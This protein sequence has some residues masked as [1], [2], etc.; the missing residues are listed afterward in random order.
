MKL[1]KFIHTNK[2]SFTEKRK[3][4]LIIAILFSLHTFS[5]EIR[6]CG[7]NNRKDF[8]L[9]K[10]PESRAKQNKLEQNI[11]KW[12]KENTNTKTS[13]ITI[14]VV[15]HVVY[16]NNL[17]NISDAQIQSQIDVLNED[18]RRLNQDASNT[19]FDFLPYAADMQIEFCLAKR[20]LGFPTNGIIR[21]QTNLA[22]F[23]LYSDSVFFTNF[24]GSSAWNTN[25]YLNIWVC[26]I[27]NNV[28]GWAQFPGGGN[29]QT[30][31][32][33]IDF[34]RIGTIG[35]VSQPYHKGRTT[36]HEVGHWL[37][38]FHVW[39]D[40]TCGDDFVSDTPEQEQANYGC[41]IHPKPSCTNSGD[42][43][44]NFMDYSDDY[45]M[46]IFTQEQKLRAMAVLNTSRFGLV[47]SDGCQTFS[48]PNSDAGITAIIN[49]NSLDVE[50][51]SPV[52]PRVVIKNF[53][54][55]TLFVATIKYSVDGG[56]PEYQ[57]WN[58]MLAQNQTDTI[59]LAGIPASGT[60]HTFNA[61]TLNPNNSTDINLQNDTKSITFS[62]QYGNKINIKIVTDNYGMETSW[63]L[64]D[65]NNNLIDFGDSLSSN[66]LYQHEYCLEDGCFH[67]V[68]SDSYGDGFCC[69]YGNGIFTI[70]KEI[71]GDILASSS[72]FTFSDTATFC[73][74]ALNNIEVSTKELKLFP[75]PTNGKIHLDFNT[76]MMQ[77]KIINTLGKV[78]FQQKVFNHS[79]LDFSY[80]PNGI[81]FLSAIS[82]VENFSKKIIISK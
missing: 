23:P 74:S 75:N 35:T 73:F 54:T 56:T 62:T 11:Q 49:P 48:I 72:P 9:Q 30:D 76:K 78:V 50:C 57:V 21:R 22:E 70:Q 44:M 77:I 42:M 71:N 68:I 60:Q 45:C 27:A 47:S 64:F 6:N 69:N 17:E 3:V 2:D 31:G 53:S 80:L 52:Y 13:A 36:T 28:L 32:I 67:F 65:A 61:S 29:T 25:K 20:Y 5:Q 10:H 59:N 55:D 58:G 39:G 79:T 34:E 66:T 82:K 4:L 15:V 26:D 38:L 81:Y 1:L 51:A 46:N 33:V 14:P 19:P 7:T 43:F 41:N 16:K 8:Y 63:Q 40:N 37:S 18:F 24:G 12:I